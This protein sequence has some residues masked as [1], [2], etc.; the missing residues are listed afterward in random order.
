MLGWLRTGFRYLGAGLGRP[1]GTR[2]QNPEHFTR[3]WNIRSNRWS[4]LNRTTRLGEITFHRGNAALSLRC[5]A[6][7]RFRCVHRRARCPTSLVRVSSDARFIG[8]C[9]YSTTPPTKYVPS[10]RSLPLFFFLGKAWITTASGLFLLFYRV[11]R[12]VNGRRFQ[13]RRVLRLDW[14]NYVWNFRSVVS[15]ILVLSYFIPYLYS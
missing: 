7:W 3:R 15:W 11:Y 12:C 8:R 2:V 9:V 13:F 4:K 14:K 10:I 6:T 1:R 5:P